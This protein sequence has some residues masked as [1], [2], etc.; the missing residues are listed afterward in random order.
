MME[1]IDTDEFGM[2]A[3]DWRWERWQYYQ[4]D[5]GQRWKALRTLWGPPIID[6]DSTRRR[7]DGV[8]NYSANRDDEWTFWSA[9]KAT[10]AIVL[11]RRWTDDAERRWKARNAHRSGWGRMAYLGVTVAYWDAG[12][13]Y[14]GY[15]SEVCSLHPGCRVQLFNDSESNL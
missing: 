1:A 2:T 14:G 9:V 6:E 4:Y 11:N 7:T 13:I 12:S 3:E 8:I 5:L 15:T 10:V